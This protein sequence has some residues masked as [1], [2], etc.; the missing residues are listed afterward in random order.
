MDRSLTYE[1]NL[2]YPINFANNTIISRAV[3]LNISISFQTNV[4]NTILQKP[5]SCYLCIV[6]QLRTLISHKL[7]IWALILVVE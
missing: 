4:S 1:W 3:D 5:A 7:V 6:R 2:T